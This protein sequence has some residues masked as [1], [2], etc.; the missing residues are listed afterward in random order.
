MGPNPR[1]SHIAQH[2]RAYDNDRYLCAL[3]APADRREHL[4]A[5]YAFNL[6]VAKTRET[7]S[8]SMIG[9]I[10]LQ[11]WR[12]AVAGIYAGT[13][14]RHE[15]VEA[16]AAA[17][18]AH[19]LTRE[20]LDALIDGRA[21]DLEDRPPGDMPEL[22]SYAAATSCGLNRLALEVLGVRTDEAVEAADAV[23]MAWAL[24]G[25]LRAMPFHARAKRLYLPADLVASTGLDLRDY[26]EL[27]PTEALARAAEM[28]ASRAHEKLAEARALRRRVPR[29]ALPT[30]LPAILA[31]RWL[32]RLARADHNPFDPALAAGGADR[33]LRVGLAALRRRY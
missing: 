24:A 10:R 27:R 22:L 29:P 13:P 5:L 26:F 28:L 21:F 25:L 16:L 19:D 17:V 1:L 33:V 4:F 32:A 23:G 3:F 6:E 9:E 15:V 2:V 18:R 7:V 12:E 14:R 8:E 11:W 31:D 30:L 20:L